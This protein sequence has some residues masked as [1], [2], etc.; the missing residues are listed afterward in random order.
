VAI[1]A[2]GER[3]RAESSRGVLVMLSDFDIT[4]PIS[5]PQPHQ[6]RA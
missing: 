3:I 5:L 2:S 1:P 6:I 4:V